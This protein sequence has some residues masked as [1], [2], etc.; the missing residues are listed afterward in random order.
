ME[1]IVRQVA[2]IEAPDRRAIEHVIG[3]R[4]SDDQKVIFQIAPAAI[5]HGAAA[6][7]PSPEPGHLPEWCNYLD[8]LSDEEADEVESIIRQRAN[9]TRPSV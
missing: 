9:L 2:D 5:G 7:P 3:R 8:G 6:G 1:T 4:L